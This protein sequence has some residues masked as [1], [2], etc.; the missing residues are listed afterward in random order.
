MA[1]APYTSS[2]SCEKTLAVWT[3]SSFNASLCEGQPSCTAASSSLQG[4]MCRHVYLSPS[5]GLE[6]GDSARQSLVRSK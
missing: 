3:L 2:K 4:S 5:S 1:F 6:R